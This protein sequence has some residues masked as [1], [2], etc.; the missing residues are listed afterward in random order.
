MSLLG[1]GII[2]AALFVPMVWFTSS[3]EAD[4]PQ[5]REMQ[6]IE[7]TIA[8]RKTPQKQPQKQIKQ[9]EEVKPEGVSR[10]ETK[11]VE[12]KKKEEKKPE[13][14]PDDKNPFGKFTRP[15][16][17]TGTPTTKPEGDFNGSEK[18]FAPTS[19]GDPFL[20]RLRADMN[21]QFPEIAKAT[22]IP[23]GCIHIQPD[24]K[25]VDTTFNPPIGM[26]G[27]DDL[28]TAA[29][30]ALK[31]LVKV[32]RANPEPVPSHLLG[33]TNQWLCFKFSVQSE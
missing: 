3:A 23:V 5:L 18:G 4:G 31:E 30:A 10:D 9:T 25:I 26:K 28:Q 8:Y 19:K 7:A 32:R 14:K 29:E 11:K 33:I 12:E 16:E 21:F 20:G 1:A 15:G 24:G 13:P 27:D 6:V 2:T 17:D 22:S